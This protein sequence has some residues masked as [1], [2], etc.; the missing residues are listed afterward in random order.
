MP[1][2]LRSRLEL[3][4]KRPLSS[5]EVET[6]SPA[7]KVLR[8]HSYIKP[9]EE[10]EDRSDLEEKLKQKIKNLQQQLRRS[11]QKVDSMGQIITSLKEIIKSQNLSLMFYFTSRGTLSHSLSRNSPVERAGSVLSQV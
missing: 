7:A 5:P 6:L 4:M 9:P 2:E 10:E 8:D 11:K 1:D 3:P